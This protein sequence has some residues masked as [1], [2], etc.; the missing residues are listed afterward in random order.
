MTIL[1]SRS[2]RTIARSLMQSSNEDRVATAKSIAN[3]TLPRKTGKLQSRMEADI[4]RVFAETLIDIGWIGRNLQYVIF[5]PSTTDLD[6]KGKPQRAGITQCVLN[7]RSKHTTYNVVC[8]LTSHA[9]ERL[10]ERRH[11]T[12]LLKIVSEEFN[13][14]F[15]VR[16][17]YS[18]VS[19]SG[20][21][22]SQPL[23]EFKIRTTNGWACG[24][25]EPGNLPTITTWY[26]A[27]E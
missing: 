26:P 7:S 3:S 5:Q 2:A 13:L 24:V 6:E 16:F 1:D 20:D 18:V 4:R 22:L 25:C 23:P 8:V 12:K 14:N 15:I 11:D 27:K 19:D 21:P 10:L 17:L 9:M